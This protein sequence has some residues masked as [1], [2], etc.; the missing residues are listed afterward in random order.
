ML[1]MY[2][3]K[4]YTKYLSAVDQEHTGHGQLYQHQDEQQDKKLETEIQISNRSDFLQYVTDIIICNPGVQHRTLFKA[5]HGGTVS[6]RSPFSRPG[7]S[8]LGKYCTPLASLTKFTTKIS[9]RS[10]KPASL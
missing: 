8:A 6:H 10:S 1:C 7:C 2:C 9:G 5:V 4:G 3:K